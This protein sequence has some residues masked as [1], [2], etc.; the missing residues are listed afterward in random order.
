MADPVQARRSL[1]LHILRW[2]HFELSTKD[3]VPEAAG[4][5]EPIVVV[6]EMV[7]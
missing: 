7:L 6:G 5:S 3:P 4:D 1:S 2:W